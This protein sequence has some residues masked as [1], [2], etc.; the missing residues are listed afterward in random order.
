MASR[1]I[2]ACFAGKLEPGRYTCQVNVLNPSEQKFAVWRSRMVL[3][4]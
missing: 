3:L 4:P 1:W 2:A